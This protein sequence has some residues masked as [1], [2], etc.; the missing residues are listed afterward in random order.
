MAYENVR[1]TFEHRPYEIAAWLEG[2]D[3]LFRLAGA[4][5]LRGGSDAELLLPYFLARSHSAY[6]AGVRLSTG[7]QVAE[8][9]M[10]SRGCLEHALYACLVCG[11]EALAVVW[12]ER[13]TSEAAT[14]KCKA[15]FTVGAAKKCLRA[16]NS[17]VG[18]IAAELYQRTIERGAHPN[19]DDWL[20]TA[21]MDGSGG[22]TQMLFAGTPAWKLSVQTT[23]QVGYC[24][25]R[26][27][28]LLY[29]QRFGA[30]GISRR[31]H[32]FAWLAAKLSEGGKGDIPRQ[33]PR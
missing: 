26:V 9:Y 13:G 3:E 11:D 25:L 12:A 7:G 17:E 22:S 16:R 24:S 30:T 15:V 20:T 27:F 10:T 32:D 33:P 19:V 8:A 4:A 14:K 18:R 28:E 21:D 29:G 5:K 23:A 2:L 1:I 6:L 31:L